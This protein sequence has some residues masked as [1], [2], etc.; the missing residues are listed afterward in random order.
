MQAVILAAGQGTRLRPFTNECPKPLVSVQG[1][2]ML[3]YQLEALDGAGVRECVIVVGCCADLVRETIGARFGNVAISYVENE[4]HDRTNNIYSLWLARRSIVDDILLLEGDLVFEPGLLLDAPY[5]NVAVVDQYNSTM[6]GTVIQAGG[7][8]ATAMVLKADQPLDFDYGSALKTVNI[9]KLSGGAVHREVMPRLGEYIAQGQTG[10]YYEIAFA[11]AIA[12]GSLRMHV[13]GAGPRWWTEIDTVDDLRHAQTMSL[14]PTRR[15]SPGLTAAR[16]GRARRTP[17]RWRWQ[18]RDGAF[19]PWDDDIDLGS[20]YGMHGLT[21]RSVASVADAFRARGFHVEEATYSG[22]TWLGIMKSHIRIDWFCYRVYN[23]H[24]VHFPNVPIPVEL[25][26][27]LQEVDFAGERF[28]VPSPPEEYIRCKYG[29]NWA[30]PKRIGYEKDVVDNF[31]AERLAWPRRLR[32]FLA[33]RLAGR[34]AVLQ[35]LGE[36]GK[37]VADGEVAVAGLGRSRTNGNRYARCY[38]P[39]EDIC[40]LVVRAEGSGRGAI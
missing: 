39:R 14:T 37:P 28:L 24:V 32:R 10:H 40:A 26:A 29:P 19:I 16:A 12:D 21:K 17:E 7:D 3:Y 5:D 15:P 33:V 23:G 11:H 34:T 8:L 1:K 25:F 13:L 30:T 35:V 31:P 4:I 2:P 20:I 27:R 9:Y 6:N 18:G 38:V 36:H 22:E